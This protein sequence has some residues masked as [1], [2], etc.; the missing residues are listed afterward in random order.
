MSVE[1]LTPARIRVAYD[2]YA[3]AWTAYCPCCVWGQIFPTWSAAIGWTTQHLSEEHPVTACRY[4]I[5]TQMPAGRDEFL[6]ELYER[7]P[8][9]TRPCRGCDGIAVY[10]AAYNTPTEVAVDLAAFGLRP[11]FCLTC[12]G[13]IALDPRPLEDLP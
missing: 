12:T 6:G 5:D 1:Q 11:I 4:C 7:C 9:C 8:V 3:W 2:A 13:V 10:P